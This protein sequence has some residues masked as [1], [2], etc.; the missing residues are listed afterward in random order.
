MAFV[1]IFIS[2][3]KWSSIEYCISNFYELTLKTYIVCFQRF[4]VHIMYEMEKP[5]H[6][7]LSLQR[8]LKSYNVKVKP[9]QHSYSLSPVFSLKIR[10]N[11]LHRNF[12]NLIWA[13]CPGKSML[14][15]LILDQ[16]VMTKFCWGRG[17][18]K[19]GEG[20]SFLCTY[21]DYC[22]SVWDWLGKETNLGG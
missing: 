16:S 9:C 18:R 5:S 11:T 4:T 7:T 14:C 22:E 12:G 2:I 8:R 13:E 10:I 20:H 17:G 6:S 15:W 21:L 19:S 3:N 1:F